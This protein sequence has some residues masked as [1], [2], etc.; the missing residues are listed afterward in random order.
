MHITLVENPG[1]A[2]GI[3]PGES[4]R[5]LILVITILTCIGIFAY[6]L[7]AKNADRRV[8]IAVALI[9]GGAAGNLFDRI[10]YGYFYNYA[11]LFQGNVVDFLDI[12]FF[13]FFIFD[14]IHGNYVFN[15]ADVSI[16]SGV[17]ILIFLILRMKSKRTEKSLV[18]Q[19]VEDREDIT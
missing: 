11:P 18:P 13:R 17:F 10:F 15:F 14:D 3:D 7:F 6:L 5:D 1:I 4:L 19:L 12:R 16:L 8:R 2:F 9:L